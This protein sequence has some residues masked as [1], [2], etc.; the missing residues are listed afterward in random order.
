M[1]KPPVLGEYYQHQNGR[2][3]LVICIARDDDREEDLVIH[4]GD[5]GSHWARTLENFMGL[6]DDKPRFVLVQK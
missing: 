3:Y 6:K 2:Q 1:T 5:D 4:V